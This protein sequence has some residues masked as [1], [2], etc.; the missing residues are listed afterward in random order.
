[1]YVPDLRANTRWWC[2]FRVELPSSSMVASAITAGATSVPVPIAAGC[3]RKTLN[4]HIREARCLSM[5]TDRRSRCQSSALFSA[6]TGKITIVIVRGTATIISGTTGAQAIAHPRCGGRQRR[7]RVLRSYARSH[8]AHPAQFSRRGH[9]NHR[10]PRH[11]RAHNQHP[12][13]EESIHREISRPPAVSVNGIGG[14]RAMKRGCCHT[15]ENGPKW[16]FLWANTA[17]HQVTAPPFAIN[18]RIEIG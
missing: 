10:T 17:L 18:W 2:G 7:H 8:H 5:A 1:M 12:G 11:R 6:A 9:R 13:P 16:D 4:T 3:T 14:F 15:L